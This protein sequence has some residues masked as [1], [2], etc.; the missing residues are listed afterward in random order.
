MIDLFDVVA[1]SFSSTPSFKPWMF[2]YSIWNIVDL[3]AFFYFIKMFNFFRVANKIP[4]QTV[5]IVVLV[6]SYIFSW[7]ALFANGYFFIEVVKLTVQYAVLFYVYFKN[8]E[9]MLNVFRILAKKVGKGK[10]RKQRRLS[11]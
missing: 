8:R 1:G 6:C 3:I 2:G 7:T 5:P 4:E 9:H 11:T 10:K